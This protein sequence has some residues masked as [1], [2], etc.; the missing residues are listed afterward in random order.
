M[1]NTVFPI[2]IWLQNAVSPMF[3]V[4]GE[5]LLQGTLCETL[6]G[7]FKMEANTTQAY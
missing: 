3:A 6:Y 2:F 5:S 7:Q 1:Q 4:Q